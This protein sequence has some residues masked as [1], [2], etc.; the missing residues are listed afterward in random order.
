MF[1]AAN[2]YDEIVNKATAE[3]LTSENW[4]LNLNVCDKVSSEG[5]TGAR[6]CL[7][8]IQKRIIHRNANVQLY[9][10]TLCD[11]LAKNC[12]VE[13]H[14]ELASRTFT[15]TLQ[16]V[17]VDRN[18]HETVR[19]KTLEMI[20]EWAKDFSSDDTLGM[21]GETM[22]ALKAQGYKFDD[23][24][25]QD[26][27]PTEPS[28]DLLR[29]EDEELRR[30]LELSM[31]DVGGR[32]NYSDNAVGGSSN[33]AGS[34]S[35]AGW[36]N[37]DSRG[38]SGSAAAALLDKSSPNPDAATSQTQQTNRA[39]PNVEHNTSASQASAVSAAPTR[40]RALYDFAPSEVGELAFNKGDIIRVLDSVYEHWWRG[41]LRGE[42]GIFPVNYVEILPTPSPSEIQREAEQEARI[43]AQAHDIDRL[44]GRLRSLDP[45]RE[46]LADDEELQDLYQASLAMRPK[47]VRLIDRYSSKVE[48][49]RSMNEKFVEAR[50][51]FDGM[52]E[53]S[54]AQHQYRGPP[55]SAGPGPAAYAGARPGYAH[56]Q[57]GGAP[58]QQA[59]WE[60]Q[61]QQQH[62]QYAQQ[63]GYQS[64]PQV[65]SASAGPPYQQAGYA[66]PSQHDQQGY[67]QWHAQQQSHPPQQP[68]HGYPSQAQQGQ[69]QDQHGYASQPPQRQTSQ[70]QQGRSSQPQQGSDPYQQTHL[71]QTQQPSQSSQGY[72]HADPRSQQSAY[73]ISS[74]G[75]PQHM[76]G[77]PSSSSSSQQQPPPNGGAGY[78]GPPV[79]VIVQ[80]DEKKRLFEQ[81]RREAEAY[82]AAYGPGG[83]GSGQ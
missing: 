82:H 57:Q 12:G 43:F 21:V 37:G 20:K 71:Q 3:T 16:R 52:M 61:Q 40:V 25:Q 59:G 2:P 67:A 83:S 72:G 51:V 13:A 73:G 34:S 7:A 22:A 33:A 69:P 39:Q 1:K 35:S 58:P 36:A 64:S 24:V 81:A 66:P 54:L 10:L 17:V 8:A 31:K 42:A 77:A 45:A 28:S 26:A 79:P 15:Q 29:K 23:P 56:S 18:T 55:G 50:S 63:Q 11:A 44:L 9:S 62:H 68:S 65:S 41:E 70:P 49:L 74:Q 48:E 4:E 38:Q 6:N 78:S 53:R 60:A 32:G 19:K 14:R 30:V 76:G 47:I 5:E 27:P 75:P 46:S 80:E